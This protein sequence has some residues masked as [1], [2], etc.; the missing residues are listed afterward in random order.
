M[1][2]EAC[3]APR[4]IEQVSHQASLAD[5][6]AHLQSHLLTRV[7]VALLPQVVAQPQSCQ[8]KGLES[9]SP[10]IYRHARCIGA[11]CQAQ[12][13]LPPPNPSARA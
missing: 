1:K 10:L 9:P 12:G 3:R 7:L 8:S 2:L 6:D 5:R 11:F 13:V 4:T